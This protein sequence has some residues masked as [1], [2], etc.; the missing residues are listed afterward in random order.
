MKLQ[1]RELAAASDQRAAILEATARIVEGISLLRNRVIVATYVEPEKTAG[2]I[3]RPDKTLDESRFQG[4]VGLVLRKGSH[5]FDFE[6]GRPENE[7]QVG[8]WVFY[9]PAD[10]MEVGIATEGGRRGEGI[11]CRIIFDDMI[12]GLIANPDAVY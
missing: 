1:L 3:I 11:S 7:P 4:K 8:D 2:G 10:A 5:A 12:M 9:R 6:E